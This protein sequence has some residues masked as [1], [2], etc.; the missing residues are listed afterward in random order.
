MIGTVRGMMLFRESLRGTGGEKVYRCWKDIEA[1]KL[2]D[3]QEGKQS[4]KQAIYSKYINE[5]SDT[6]VVSNLKIN[7]FRGKL[8]NYSCMFLLLISTVICQ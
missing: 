2:T 6:E 7:V 3:D 4:W 1:W 8:I 5:K